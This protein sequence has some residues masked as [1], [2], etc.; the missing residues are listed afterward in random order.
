MRIYRLQGLA[1]LLLAVGCQTVREAR[2]T[3]SAP[4]V[5]RH[6][7]LF[8][9]EEPLTLKQSELWT[10]AYHPDFAI[11]TQ[12]VVQAEIALHEAGVNLRPQFD[13]T[14]GISGNSKSS[15]RNNWHIHSSH[16][17]LSASL[18]LSWV[19]YDF[20]RT[21]AKQ[22]QAVA[23]LQGAAT[24]YRETTLE[25][26]Y[27]T[28]ASFYDLAKANEE[29]HVA[30]ENLRLYARLREEAQLKLDIGKGRRY[31][32]TKAA[33]E[34]TS[35]RVELT[36]ASNQLSVARA[37]LLN[38]LSIRSDGFI[39]YRWEELPSL[40]VE[41][42]SDAFVLAR[43]NNPTLCIQYANRAAAS[44]AVDLAI[45]DLYPELSISLSP[46][47]LHNA[48][49]TVGISWGGHL[50]DT[51]F[52]GFSKEDN[53]KRATSALK[54]ANAQLIRQEEALL[55]ELETA[56]ADLHSAQ[57]NL[58]DATTLQRQATENFELV[59]EEFKVGKATILERSDAQTT[60]TQARVKHLTAACTVEKSKAKLFQLLGVD[61]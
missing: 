20:G 54:Q 16:E 60:L 38:N 57:D 23:N 56:W 4:L 34:E 7:A 50:I 27:Q 1:L 35:A 32:L 19:L 6:Y 17:A 36:V 48:A 2:K 59:E 49:E 18:N 31:D 22:R 14:I 8:T 28:R 10:L 51:L 45:A 47:Y 41:T 33:A 43:T 61:L 13:A 46:S 30:E 40:P 37:A 53:L 21:R 24:S 12:E 29:C 44:N 3:Q 9:P 11:A 55:M 5:P 25:R 39:H 26:I 58:V 52:S 42:L 15:D